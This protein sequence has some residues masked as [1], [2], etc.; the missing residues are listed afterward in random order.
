MQH[1]GISEELWRLKT[2]VMIK[3]NF[4]IYPH[5]KLILYCNKN[6]NITV[7]LYF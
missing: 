5:R 6:Q 2:R 3:L 4:R 7:L 1:I